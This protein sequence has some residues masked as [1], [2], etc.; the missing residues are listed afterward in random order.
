[1]LQIRIPFNNA[2]RAQA[3]EL[4]LRVK[5]EELDKVRLKL[6]MADADFGGSQAQQVQA[7]LSEV[8]G[9]NGPHRL[10][11]A[12]AERHVR[13]FLGENWDYISQ[14]N[15]L[16]GSGDDSDPIDYDM[17]TCQ[18]FIMWAWAHM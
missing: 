2:S 17:K 9:A 10:L 13:T 6:R 7:I 1:M 12:M 15:D 4:L 3:Q 11:K 8:E 5:V 14:A 16:A 18:L